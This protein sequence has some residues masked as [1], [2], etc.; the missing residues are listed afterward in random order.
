M[1]EEEERGGD[2][3]NRLDERERESTAAHSPRFICVRF[4]VSEF[5][6]D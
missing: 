3:G 5:C 6:M 1:E 2:G 4:V